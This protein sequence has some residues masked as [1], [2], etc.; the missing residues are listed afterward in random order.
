LQIYCDDRTADMEIFKSE[1]LQGVPA[2][3]NAAGKTPKS[4]KKTKKKMSKGN[5]YAIIASVATACVFLVVSLVLVFTLFGDSLF[6]T[7][8]VSTG[9]S[10]NSV[11]D[12]YKPGELVTSCV[13]VDK[14]QTVPNLVRV[15]LAELL[16]S[17]QYENF[18]FIVTSKKYDDKIPR[19][20]IISQ[21]IPEGTTFKDTVEIEVVVSLG[22][23][24]IAIPNVKN[25]RED[26]AIILLLKAGFNFNNIEIIDRWDQNAKPLSI[27]GTEP[28]IGKKT[29][30]DSKIVMYINTY[31]GEDL[32]GGEVYSS[33]ST[34]TNQ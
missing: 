2:N 7:N 12:V 17:E 24:E 13:S 28:E 8:S 3:T 19:G 32:A 11:P 31:T 16:S 22:P 14:I 4:G 20:T 9:N 23:Q 25:M 34:T 15:S 30:V 27:I 18:K 21:N 10:E 26:E 29:N 5:R 6:G 1:F 33:D